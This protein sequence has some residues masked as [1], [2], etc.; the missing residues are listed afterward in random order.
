MIRVFVDSSVLFSA[1][2]S[3]SGKAHDLIQLGISKQVMLVISDDVAT[4]VRRNFAIDYPDRLAVVDFFFDQSAFEVATDPT[5]EEIQT[6]ARYTALKDAPIV[7]AALKAECS[8][9]A[10]Y[11]HKHLLDRPEVAEQSGLKIVTPADILDEIA[12][13]SE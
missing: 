3:A 4:E 11:D 13:T 6:A 10:T 1:A 9:L 8:H 2:Y 7:A 12:S 5:P